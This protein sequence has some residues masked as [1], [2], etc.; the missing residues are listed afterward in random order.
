[1]FFIV[2]GEED[3]DNGLCGKVNP[4][5]AAPDNFKKSRRF[6]ITVYHLY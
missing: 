5:A 1:M 4:I 2:T 6:M 3:L